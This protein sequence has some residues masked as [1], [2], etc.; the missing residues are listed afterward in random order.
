M[1]HRTLELA[2][3][4]LLVS[5]RIACKDADE[6]KPYH[7]T[8]R[9]TQNGVDR[10]IVSCGFFPCEYCPVKCEESDLKFGE[11]C[12]LRELVNYWGCMEQG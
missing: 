1:A 7:R 4:A 10:P 3:D 11:P 2:S 5:R 6:E 8:E 12:Q 9:C